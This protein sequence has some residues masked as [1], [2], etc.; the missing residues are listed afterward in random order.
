[1]S[2]GPPVQECPEG[3]H[4]GKEQMKTSHINVS[5]SESSQA[6][7]ND[8]HQC[9]TSVSNIPILSMHEWL[10]KVI[11]QTPWFT[12]PVDYF[13]TDAFRKEKK[14]MF[15]RIKLISNWIMH[16]LYTWG[17]VLSLPKCFYDKIKVGWIPNP[18]HVLILVINAF[19]RASRI[20][21]Q[22]TITS[23]LFSLLP[24]NIK[25]KN[26]WFQKSEI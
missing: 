14:E 7:S 17:S 15:D 8:S 23:L 2:G 1:M 4:L 5:I 19:R 13:L 25:H 9:T 20:T 6:G 26:L 16:Q 10:G 22:L 3:Y 12:H 21:C 24:V 11:A 18:I